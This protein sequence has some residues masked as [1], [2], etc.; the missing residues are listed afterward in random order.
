MRDKLFPQK[1]DDRDLNPDEIA[2]IQSRKGSAPTAY[3]GNLAQ[4][5]FGGEKEE[6]E[7]PP[8]KQ[9]QKKA[10]PVSH[11]QNCLL[12]LRL[13]KMFLMKYMYNVLWIYSAIF[14][15]ISRYAIVVVLP[16]FTMFFAIFT[17]AVFLPLDGM[18]V[19]H[20]LPPQ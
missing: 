2:Q 1:Q 5:L 17:W 7:R 10:I 9:Q 13:F 12:F 14:L 6:S 3:I 4:Q 15:H 11:V 8:L 19:R 16:F 20:R 18:T